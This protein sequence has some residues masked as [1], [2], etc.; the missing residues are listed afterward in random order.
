MA[1]ATCKK[2]QI[3]QASRI[4]KLLLIE[5]QQRE[6]FLW[7]PQEQG[8]RV[9]GFC[10]LILVYSMFSFCVCFGSNGFVFVLAVAVLC[11]SNSTLSSGCSRLLS[12]AQGER[13][14]LLWNRV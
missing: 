3:C 11:L 2:T 4:T 5:H 7:N 6:Q 8:Q 12:I 9:T 10:L 1:A 13:K 14:R